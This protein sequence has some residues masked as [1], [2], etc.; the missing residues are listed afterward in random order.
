MIRALLIAMLAIAAVPARAEMGEAELLRMAM[1]TPGAAFAS[2]SIPGCG[3]DERP[4]VSFIEAC[5]ERYGRRPRGAAATGMAACISESL[6]PVVDQ[7]DALNKEDRCADWGM[8]WFMWGVFTARVVSDL[9]DDQPDAIVAAATRAIE[10]LDGSGWSIGAAETVLRFRRA[11]AFAITG[12]LD[13][14]INDAR[15]VLRADAR[16]S[17]ARLEIEILTGDRDGALVTRTRLDALA[18]TYEGRL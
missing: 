2:Q 11:E 1:M 13:A 14:G 15:H 10:L 5:Q 4:W 16:G 7:V 9:P 17:I 18:K 12:D 8:A 6:Y 3:D